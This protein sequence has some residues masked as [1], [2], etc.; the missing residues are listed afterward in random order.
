MSPDIPFK[1]FWQLLRQ[2]TGDDAYERYRAHHASVHEQCSHH[3][4]APLSRQQFFKLRQEEKWSRVSR[5][6]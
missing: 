2:L 6:C 5:C 4:E 3:G 1:R